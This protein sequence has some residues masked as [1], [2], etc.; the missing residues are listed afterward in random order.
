MDD[1]FA[2]QTLQALRFG[3]SV[4]RIINSA[5][6]AGL[7]VQSA[8][9]QLDSSLQVARGT[10]QSLESR[11]KT[12]SEVYTKAVAMVASLQRK[13]DDLVALQAQ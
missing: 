5:A 9:G 11:G 6:M 12:Q 7:S 13:R 2:A 1:A 3:E 8:L 10:L 4:A